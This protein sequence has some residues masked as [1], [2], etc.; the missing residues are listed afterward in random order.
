MWLQQLLLLLLPLLL[1]LLLLLFPSCVKLPP[2][3]R[4]VA[5]AN[6]SHFSCLPCG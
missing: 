4:A 2:L 1:L 3:S 6:V 5:R